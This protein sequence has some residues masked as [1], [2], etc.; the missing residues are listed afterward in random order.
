MGNVGVDANICDKWYLPRAPFENVRIDS[1]CDCI[2]PLSTDEGVRITCMF[3]DHVPSLYGRRVLKRKANT[4]M[5]DLD[6]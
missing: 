3:H 2:N 1:Q 6:E 5:A 4:H